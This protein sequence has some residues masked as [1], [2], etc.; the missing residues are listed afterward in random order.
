MTIRFNPDLYSTVLAGLNSNNRD[1]QQVLLELSSGKRVNVPSDDPAAN[2]TAMNIQA[3][4]DQTDQFT[5]NISSVQGQL[6]MAD[7]TMNSVTTFLTQAITLGTQ[8]GNSTLS[9]S[10]RTDISSQI[11]A[12]A[13]QIM[14]LANTT[15]QGAYIFAGTASNAPPYTANPASPNGVTYNGNTATNQVEIS[16]GQKINLNLP[17][18]QIFTNGGAEVFAALTTLAQ[19]AQSGTGVSAAL[20]QL[21]TAFDHISAQRAFYG[22]NLNQ[23]DSTQNILAADKVQLSSQQNTVV[24]ADIATAATQLSQVTTAR[25]ALLAAGGRIKG[26]NLFDFLQ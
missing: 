26:S 11:Q 19:A 3:Q 20:G 18:S 17:G 16:Q 9:P 6:Q 23:L 4:Q 14:A 2:A 12:V 13:T 10:N 15:Y 5:Q 25:S 22:S 8:A 1:Q 7:S 24:G 21:R